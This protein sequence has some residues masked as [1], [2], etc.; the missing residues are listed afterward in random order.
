M[1][2]THNSEVW[3]KRLSALPLESYSAGDTVF[4]EGSKTGRLLILKSGAVAIVKNGV[5]IAISTGGRSPAMAK[6][7]RKWLE[8]GLGEDIGRMLALQERMRGELKASIPDQRRREVVIQ[9]ILEDP[10]VWDALEV[11]PD[12]AYEIA[13]RH[14][15]G[16]KR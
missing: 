6:F 3:E 5:E 2:L 9:K 7:L 11:A 4:T 8:A 1:A 12:A 14:Q 16:E 10:E 13:K 15:G